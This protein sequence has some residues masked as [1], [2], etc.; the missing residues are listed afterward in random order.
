MRNHG[1]VLLCAILGA[2]A[3]GCKSKEEQLADELDA[4]I[5]WAATLEAVT[6]S[7]ADNRVPARYV[8]RTIAESRDAFASAG[9]T[10]AAAIATALD[11]VVRRNDRRA[12]AG[13]LRALH[14]ER[15]VLESSL[16]R[17][18]PSR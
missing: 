10:R 3:T 12:L 15:G 18:K 2:I 16:A 13:P 6:K 1:R 5:S 7:W 4:S 17:V 9:Q 8:E 14:A 11:A